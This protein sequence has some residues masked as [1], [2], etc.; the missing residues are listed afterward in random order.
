MVA[1]LIGCD[2]HKQFL[3]PVVENIPHA[4]NAGVKRIEQATRL[5]DKAGL[6]NLIFTSVCLLAV[7]GVGFAVCDFG[8]RNNNTGIFFG[9]FF[10]SC[11]GVLFCLKNAFDWKHQKIVYNKE[12]SKV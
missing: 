7:S 8:S 10:I 2:G 12:V 4:D 6:Y 11:S 1:L 5:V 3:S 9:G